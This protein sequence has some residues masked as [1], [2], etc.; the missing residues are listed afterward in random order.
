MHLIIQS[1]KRSTEVL[2]VAS[3]CSLVQLHVAV[4]DPAPLAQGDR[5]QPRQ[6]R[7][8]HERHKHKTQPVH[9]GAGRLRPGGDVIDPAGVDAELA[10]KAAGAHAG[11][12]GRTVHL[13]TENARRHRAGDG[14]R[15]SRRDPDADV[16]DDV[17]HLEPARADALRDKA[18]PAVLAEAHHRE[19]DHL[20]A[21]AR[22][23]RAAGKSRQPQRR[24]DRCRGDR[25]RQRDADEDRD[26]DAHEERL[27]LRGPHD[28]LSHGARR[29]ADGRR[30]ELGKSDAR[31]DRHNRRDED[32]DLCLLADDLAQLGGEDRHEQ[33]RERA[34]R[35][36]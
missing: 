5:E 25:E 11:G 16:A 18:A 15:Q 19:A 22:D 14:R 36:A 13:Q 30:D 8:Q 1:K 2:P 17:A 12:D 32:V 4:F 27:Q 28:G 35:A 3:Y 33:H 31:E 29:R 9:A 21:A 20:R 6:H 24:A 23:G 34:A 26:D 10:D 7:R